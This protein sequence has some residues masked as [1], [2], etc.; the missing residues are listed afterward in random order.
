MS[1]GCDSG[2]RFPHGGS[3]IVLG[4][5]RA[6]RPPSACVPLS[7]TFPVC[8]VGGTTMAEATSLD[9]SFIH[10]YIN[11]YIYLFIW[12]RGVLVAACGI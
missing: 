6:G 5:L 7:L 4:Y 3:T 2:A 10:I 11:I 8:K 9:M 1:H 12:L